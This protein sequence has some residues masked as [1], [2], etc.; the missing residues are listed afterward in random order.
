MMMLTMREFVL[1]ES[2]FEVGQSTK[3]SSLFDRAVTSF[4]E[5]RSD[6]DTSLEQ[7]AQSSYMM[8]ECKRA[9]RDY[10]GSRLLLFR[11]NP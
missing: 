2:L 1:G 6:S 3:D 4:E 9:I 8:G 10:A 11:Y 5:V 7:R